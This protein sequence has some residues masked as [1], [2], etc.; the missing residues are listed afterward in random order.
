[1]LSL[2]R[3]TFSGRVVG[4]YGTLFGR[5]NLNPNSTVTV[6]EYISVVLEVSDIRVLDRIFSTRRYFH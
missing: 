6:S 5:I 3:E 4:L 2:Q 1:M